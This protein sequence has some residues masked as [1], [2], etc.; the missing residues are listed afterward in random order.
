MDFKS[1]SILQK[2][3]KVRVYSHLYIIFT[4]SGNVLFLVDITIQ[5]LLLLNLLIHIISRY[6][7]ITI[8]YT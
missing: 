4:I 3:Y 7:L 5:I 6:Q 1:K 2:F 8:K